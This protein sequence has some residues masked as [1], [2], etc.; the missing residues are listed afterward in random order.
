M[1]TGIFKVD[2]EKERYRETL[3]IKLDL[4]IES[5][6]IFTKVIEDNLSNDSIHRSPEL[7]LTDLNL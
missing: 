5:Q 1:N 7:L 6:L 4:H 2:Y 3:Y